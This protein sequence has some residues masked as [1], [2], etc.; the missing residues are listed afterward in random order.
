MQIQVTGQQMEITP[1]RDYAVS[2]IERI[3]TCSTTPPGRI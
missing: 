1:A 2:K 3:T